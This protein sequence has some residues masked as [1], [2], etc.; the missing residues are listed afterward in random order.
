[1]PA[2]SSAACAARLRARGR[3]PL[4]SGRAAGRGD[5]ARG[6]HPPEARARVSGTASPCAGPDG[7]TAPGRSKARSWRLAPGRTAAP[8][9]PRGPCVASGLVRTVQCSRGSGESASGG[10]ADELWHRL[11]GAFATGCGTLA[12]T[13][14]FRRQRPNSRTARVSPLL[15]STRRR[16]SASAM[17]SCCGP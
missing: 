3:R 2:C 5:R 16:K 17:C 9:P 8:Q 11:D 4:A 1:M 15:F 13:L 14:Q 12:V 10:Q 6:C 7:W